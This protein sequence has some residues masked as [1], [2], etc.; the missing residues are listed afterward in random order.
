[1]AF[2][3][4]VVLTLLWLSLFG[5]LIVGLARLRNWLSRSIVSRRHWP[6]YP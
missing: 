4:L 5:L 6:P 3:W 1:M 2:T